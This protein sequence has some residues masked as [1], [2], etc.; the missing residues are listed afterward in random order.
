MTHIRNYRRDDA[1]ALEHCIVE[2]QSYEAEIEPNRVEGH[3]VAAAYR[4]L[5]LAQ[6]RR[7]AGKII[8]AEAD[9]EVVGFVC[10]LAQVDSKDVLEK[11]TQHAY[12]TDLVVLPG[13]RNEGVGRALLAAAEKYVAGLG[14]RVLKVD[15]LAANDVALDLY[16][17]MGYVENEIRLT[18]RLDGP[19][20]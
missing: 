13:H 14:G 16:V 8:V 4:R 19:A 17:S 15:V 9:D 20:G 3:R 12:I 2:L 1:L 6:C 5:L 18:K 7:A 10:V 11:D